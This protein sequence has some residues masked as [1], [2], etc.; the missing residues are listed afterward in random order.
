MNKTDKLIL[1]MEQDEMLFQKLVRFLSK[2]L[3]LF[4]VEDI[5]K[6]ADFVDNQHRLAGKQQQEDAISLFKKITTE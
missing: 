2:R 3:E 6:V 4:S 1:E 5:R